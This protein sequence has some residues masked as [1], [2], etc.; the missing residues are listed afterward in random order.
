VATA[1]SRINRTPGPQYRPRSRRV[2][3]TAELAARVERLYVAC[4]SLLLCFVGTAIGFSFGVVPYFRS[5]DVSQHDWFFTGSIV[6]GAC[7]GFVVGFANGAR[8]YRATE[9]TPLVQR[10]MLSYL[11]RRGLD[12]RGLP[13]RTMNNHSLR[14]LLGT[15]RITRG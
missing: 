12:A 9:A 13:Q 15:R 2:P 4:V 6:V 3:P 11:Q 7:V 1:P 8:W 5:A 14:A 10:R